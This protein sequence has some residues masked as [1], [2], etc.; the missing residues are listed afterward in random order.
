MK[1]LKLL[2]L[3]AILFLEKEKSQH[4]AY[5]ERFNCI[6]K[7]EFINNYLSLAF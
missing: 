5:I 6:L 2:A 7:K 3:G 1:N 4:N